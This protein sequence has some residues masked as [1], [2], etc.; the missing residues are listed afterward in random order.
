MVDDDLFES[1]LE[2][3]AW[4]WDLIDFWALPLEIKGHEPPVST[5][6]PAS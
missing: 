2:E 4:H 6:P 3:F 1:N 5:P